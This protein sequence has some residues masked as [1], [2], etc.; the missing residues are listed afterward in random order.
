MIDPVL[1]EKYTPRPEGKEVINFKRGENKNIISVIHA[2]I[3]RAVRQVKYIAPF[4]QGRDAKET[5]YNIHEYLRKNIKY[6][7]DGTDKQRIRLPSDLVH[8]KVGD[9][10]SFTLFSAAILSAL[11]YK[12]YMEYASYNVLD[13]RPTHVYSVAFAGDQPIYLDAVHTLFG[14]RFN[15]RKPPQYIKDYNMQISTISGTK[16]RHRRPQYRSTVSGTM[17]GCPGNV[18]GVMIGGKLKD[19]VKKTTS[20]VSQTVKKDLKKVQATTKK[21]STNL[22]GEIKKDLKKTQATVKAGAK[23]VQKGAKGV[24]KIAKKVTGA[25]PREAFKSLILLNYRGWANILNANM[26]ASV[27]RW[28]QL[29]GDESVIRRAIA[30]GMKK[31]PLL[32]GKNQKLKIKNLGQGQYAISGLVEISG[33]M[34][35]SIGSVAAIL[36]AAAAVIAA[37]STILNKGGGGVDVDNAGEQGEAGG[38]GD[39]LNQA[40]DIFK[41]GADLVNQFTGGGSGGGSATQS[42]GSPSTQDKTLPGDGSSASGGGFFSKPSNLLLTGAAVFLGG[43]ALKLF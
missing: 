6:V 38:E 43:K 24:L 12:N 22:K 36:T 14:G 37:F 3:G 4:F 28:K 31:N 9:C 7:N 23:T 39:I 17:I 10:K 29:G 5:A 33:T 15:T 1:I 27:K 42:E 34:I 19:A 13:S 26:D 32:A 8:N 21:A 2:N 41:A 11:K 35:G 20:K 18:S 30:E 16:F 40:T 25:A